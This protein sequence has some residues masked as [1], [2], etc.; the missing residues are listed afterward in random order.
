MYWDNFYKE[1]QNT[2]FKDRHWIVREFPELRDRLDDDMKKEKE[3]EKDESED[4]SGVATKV[5]E[6]GCGVG[7][8]I[9]PLLSSSTSSHS[10]EF[11]GFDFSQTALSIILQHEHFDDR[12]CHLSLCDI[13]RDIWPLPTS[14][15]VIDLVTMIFVLSAIKP[16][17]LQDD[18]REEEKETELGEGDDVKGKVD[19]GS[20]SSGP[21]VVGT[22]QYVVE[23]VYDVIK[24]GGVVFVRDYAVGDM[25]QLRFEAGFGKGREGEKKLGDNL[26][27]RG[28]GTTSYFFTPGKQA[29]EQKSERCNTCLRFNM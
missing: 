19:E 17:N 10:F 8:T 6:L 7:N 29:S 4:E 12:R 20:S 15:P 13:S 22:M 5:L 27:V 1:K 26:Y 24:E 2:F 14:E 28:D 3:K 21:S 16:F 11:Y 25:S 23:K 18:K 9:F